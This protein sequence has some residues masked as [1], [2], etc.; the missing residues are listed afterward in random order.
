MTSDLNPEGL[1]S[2][3][4]S[5]KAFHKLPECPRWLLAALLTLGSA[6]GAEGVQVFDAR[7]LQASRVSCAPEPLIRVV[8]ALALCTGA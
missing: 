3:I 2:L 6:V 7:T 1:I 5:V 4:A 8:I